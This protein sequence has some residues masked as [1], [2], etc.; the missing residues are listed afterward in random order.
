[1]SSSRRDKVAKAIQAAVADFLTRFMTKS[2]PGF[3]T[4]SH[5]K[6]SNDLKVASV[7]FSILGAEAAITSSLDVLE[8]HKGR[9][10]FHIG[11]EVPLKYVPELR[12]FNDDTMAYMDH[13]NRILRKLN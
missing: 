6:M 13:M 2:T 3:V 12:F 5:V 8:H 1:V 4:V 7:Y 10:R 11:K 9:I